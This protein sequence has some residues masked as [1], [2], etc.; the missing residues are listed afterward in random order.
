MPETAAQTRAVEQ[1]ASGAWHRVTV[2]AV[3]TWQSAGSIMQAA[4]SASHA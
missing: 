4:V 2:A 3:L 1:L